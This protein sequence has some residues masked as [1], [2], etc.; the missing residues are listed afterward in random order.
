[1]DESICMCI[2]SKKNVQITRL[3]QTI[4]EISVNK[5]EVDLLWQLL[6]YS[7]LLCFTAPPHHGYPKCCCG[8]RNDAGTAS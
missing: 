4:R 6:L 3:E 2:H 7:W 8:A 1:M 5:E